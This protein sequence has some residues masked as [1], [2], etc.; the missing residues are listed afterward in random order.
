MEVRQWPADRHIEPFVDNNVGFLQLGRA[1]NVVG[2]IGVE[3]RA[4][5]GIV[6]CLLSLWVLLLVSE[7]DC[8]SHPPPNRVIQASPKTSYGERPR[9]GRGIGLLAGT[10]EIRGQMNS[11]KWHT[12]VQTLADLR[13]RTPQHIV[14]LD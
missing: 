5:Q 4:Q 10:A 1:K 12:D 8:C 7:T 2:T 13:V 11:G 3:P 6:S 14:Q 9:E